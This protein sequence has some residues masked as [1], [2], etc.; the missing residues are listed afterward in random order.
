VVAIAGDR[1]LVGGTLVALSASRGLAITTRLHPKLSRGSMNDGVGPRGR[2]RSPAVLQ[3][4]FRRANAWAKT[5]ATTVATPKGK[6]NDPGYYKH[7]AEGQGKSHKD[8][9][10]AEGHCECMPCG[11][12]FWA[13]ACSTREGVNRRAAAPRSGYDGRV[14]RDPRGSIWQPPI[15][16]Y[17][18]SASCRSDHSTMSCDG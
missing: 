1:V 15:F 16:R 7:D 18:D 3:V 14:K 5:P 2:L 11:S 12:A 6:E 13:D 9:R 10:Q 8:K 4:P 17:R